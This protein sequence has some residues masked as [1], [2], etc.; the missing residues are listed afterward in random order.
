MD[1]WKDEIQSVDDLKDLTKTKRKKVAKQCCNYY[2]NG[3][4]DNDDCCIIEG[5]WENTCGMIEVV[6]ESFKTWD[7]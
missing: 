4:L 5:N 7:N 6:I 3:C 1:N 2:Y